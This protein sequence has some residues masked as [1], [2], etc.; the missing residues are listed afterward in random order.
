MK[1]SLNKNW[2]IVEEAIFR[3]YPLHTSKELSNEMLHQIFSGV[4]KG[5]VEKERLPKPTTLLHYAA[6]N[7]MTLAEICEPL[8]Y[9]MTGKWD[10]VCIPCDVFKAFCDLRLEDG[11]HYSEEEEREME[12]DAYWDAVCNERRLREII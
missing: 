11:R 10:D 2:D 12:D 6:G 5:L 1:I 4:T 8:W 3:N 9:M 7:E